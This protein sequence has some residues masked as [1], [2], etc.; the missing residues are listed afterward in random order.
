MVDVLISA[1]ELHDRLARENDRP[2]VL[3]VRWA[4]GDPHGHEHYVER[5]IPGSVY[6][7]MNTDLAAH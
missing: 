3:D 6:V 4:L 7:D 1:T 5:R 2:L